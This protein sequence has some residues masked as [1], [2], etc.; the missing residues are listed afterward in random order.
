MVCIYLLVKL[1]FCLPLCALSAAIYGE[2]RCIYTY[3][4]RYAREIIT[5]PLHE[6]YK[7]NDA[8]G[9]SVRFS[10]H[11]LTFT[12][13]ICPRPSVCRPSVFRLSSVTFVHSTQAIEIFGNVSI[14]AIRYAGHML[15]SR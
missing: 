6:W 11:E 8:A 10:E 1:L 13:A 12:F 5:T 14:Y 15:T 4:H 7:N 2:Q 3:R 9:A